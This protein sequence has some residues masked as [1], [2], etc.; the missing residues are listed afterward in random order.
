MP[1]SIAL[2]DHP[3][4]IAGWQDLPVV[5][6]IRDVT[7]RLV[8]QAIPTQVEPTGV[9]LAIEALCERDLFVV[10][11]RLVMKYQDPVLV[12]RRPKFEQCMLI[13]HLTEIDSTNLSNK[14]RPKLPEAYT[15]WT[16]L[17]SLELPES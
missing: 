16:S 1:Q 11:E 2:R 6:Q 4:T 9:Q 13:V 15:H 5:V 7:E 17:A 12:D 8:P 10:R 3:T 14:C